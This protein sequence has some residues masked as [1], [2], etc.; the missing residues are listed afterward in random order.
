[1]RDDLPFLYAVFVILALLLVLKWMSTLPVEQFLWIG[2]LLFTVIVPLV[3]FLGLVFLISTIAFAW[4][5]DFRFSYL[6]LFLILMLIFGGLRMSWDH[7]VQVYKA[8]Q[9]A[10]DTG[11]LPGQLQTGEE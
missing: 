3:M 7:H 10:S 6:G 8:S 11:R 4:P 2:Q 5:C 9:A 1:M